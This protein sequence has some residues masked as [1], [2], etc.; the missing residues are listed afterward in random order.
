MFICEL[1]SN[2]ME[3][4]NSYILLGG[5]LVPPCNTHVTT[6]VIFIVYTLVPAFLFRLYVL[7]MEILS[8][9][10]YENKVLQVLK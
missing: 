3:R 4:W 9:I 10:A 7:H 6:Y 8:N 1:P 2:Y 5:V